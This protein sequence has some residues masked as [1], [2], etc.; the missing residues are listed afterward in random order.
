M[1]SEKMQDVSSLMTEL[2]ELRKK[3]KELVSL[4]EELSARN[5]ALERAFRQVYTIIS[6]FKQHHEEEDTK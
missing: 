6:K 5:E 2:E 4:N 1:S 3:N